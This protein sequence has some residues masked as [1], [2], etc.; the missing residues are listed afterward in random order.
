MMFLSMPK[1]SVFKRTL[2]RFTHRLSLYTLFDTNTTEISVN[3]MPF[4]G[5][6]STITEHLENFGIMPYS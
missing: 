5:S 4:K 2:Y 6:N 1:Y 3:A